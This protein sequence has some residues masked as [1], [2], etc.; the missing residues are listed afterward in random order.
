MRFDYLV[1]FFESSYLFSL[2]GQVILV[3]QILSKKHTEG[4]SYYTQLLF[5][6][7]QIIKIFYFPNTALNNYILCWIEYI[8][9]SLICVFMLYLFRK[10]KRLSMEKERNFYD[11]RIIIVV[12]M[13]FATVSLYEKSYREF[14]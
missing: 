8:L 12:S 10:Y 4:I 7:A 5:A 9:S 14:S 2:I 13:V 11:Y 1:M 6:I 3:R